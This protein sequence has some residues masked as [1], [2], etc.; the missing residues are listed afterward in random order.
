MPQE[1]I[2]RVI[3]VSGPTLRKHYRDELDDG[4]AQA[5]RSVAQSLYMRATGDG[6]DAVPACIFWLKT[7]ARWREDVVT[8][9]ELEE[10]MLAIVR[11]V[12]E[13]TEGEAKD[14]A[15]RGIDAIMGAG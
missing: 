14:R 10:K 15:L 1:A 12:S 4:V 8:A 5:N 2:A 6:R 11:V 9:K 13:N 3:G 7:R